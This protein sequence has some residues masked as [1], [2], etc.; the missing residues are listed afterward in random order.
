MQYYQNPFLTL[1]NLTVQENEEA[2]KLVNLLFMDTCFTLLLF[3]AIEKSEKQV[4]LER[5]PDEEW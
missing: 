3:A 1:K 2:C 4:Q 5:S